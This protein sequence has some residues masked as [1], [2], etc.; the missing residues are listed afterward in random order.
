MPDNPDPPRLSYDQIRPLLR[1]GDVLL[2]SG[3]AFFSRLIQRKTGSRYSHVGL[4]WKNDEAERV[5][6]YE[7]VESKGVIN[8]PFSRYLSN[9]KG[10]GQPYPGRMFI[11]R[12]DGFACLTPADRMAFLQFAID[13]QGHE[14]DSHEITRIAVAIASPELAWDPAFPEVTVGKRY[15]CSVYA[16]DALQTVRLGVPHDPRGFLAPADFAKAPDV[17]VL[18]EIV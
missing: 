4:F 9:Y 8:N 3:T 2:C 14:Y 6:V 15:I 1:S 17:S 18:W 13:V 11:A 10:E 7:S 5:M 12:H 16:G